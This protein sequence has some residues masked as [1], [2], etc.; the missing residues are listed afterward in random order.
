MKNVL[1]RFFEIVMNICSAIYRDLIGIYL[2]VKVENKIKRFTNNKEVLSDLFAKLVKA[3]PNKPCIIFQ[4]QTWT[5][6]DV[7]T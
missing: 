7:I 4:D 5:F 6:H 2:V 1:G 3:H